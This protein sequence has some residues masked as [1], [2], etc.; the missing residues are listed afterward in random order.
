MRLI[1]VILALAVV[2]C[3]DTTDP[4]PQ[5]V[6][7]T[8]QLIRVEGDALPADVS[9][10][11]TTKVMVVSGSLTFGAVTP[12]ATNN[13]ADFEFTRVTTTERTTGGVKSTSTAMTTGRAWLSGSGIAYSQLA[14]AT[15]T[16]FAMGN[17]SDGRVTYEAYT[18]SR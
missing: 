14:D 8:Y 15:G 2:G 17:A 9:T 12:T 6:A 16:R 18:Y 13:Y 7:G 11:T 4:E 3:S 5:D 1:A 10:N